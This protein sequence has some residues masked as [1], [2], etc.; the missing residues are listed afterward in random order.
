M[1]FVTSSQR[2]LLLVS[3]VGLLVI[4][5]CGTSTTAS[6]TSSPSSASATTGT[7]ATTI[8]ASTSLC[9]LLSLSQVGAVLGGTVTT[10]NSNITTSGAFKAVNCTYLGPA[11]R[12]DAEISYEFSP[13]GQ[14][15]YAA[16]KKDD[17]SR[18]E[19]ETNLTGL[20]DAAFWA[21]A[22]RLPHT[23]QVSVLK[24]NVLMLMTLGGLNPDGSTMLNGAIGL[25]NAA[26][27]SI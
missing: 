7:G 17:A 6:T 16:D 3:L 21:V 27:P 22:G 11:Q 23:L 24:G 4:A 15:S 20:G 25:A 26:L 1:R 5:A 8:T 14:A 12:L 18:G 9:K 2:G 10:L 19:T 13:N